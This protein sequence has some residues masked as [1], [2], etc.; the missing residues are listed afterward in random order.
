MLIFLLHRLTRYVILDA[1]QYNSKDGICPPTVCIPHGWR[2]FFLPPIIRLP[3]YHPT[4]YLIIM[5]VCKTHPIQVDT[6]IPQAHAGCSLQWRSSCVG[7]FRFR[8]FSCA[9]TP[10]GLHSSWSVMQQ[11]RGHLESGSNTIW[12]TW[13]PSSLLRFLAAG[14]GDPVGFFL[15]TA[16]SK[17]LAVCLNSTL[18]SDIELIFLSLIQRLPLKASLGV[19]RNSEVARKSRLWCH[20]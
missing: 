8:T 11:S 2:A 5:V 15:C 7:F 9:P 12:P 3:R 20:P 14:K 1:V 18:I 10:S 19:I 4:P 17:K 6:D 13:S 16:F